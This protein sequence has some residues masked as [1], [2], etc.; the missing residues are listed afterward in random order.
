MMRVTKHYYYFAWLTLINNLFSI[1]T[2]GDFVDEGPQNSTDNI[3]VDLHSDL[4]TIYEDDDN[5]N[6]SSNDLETSLS[7]EQNSKK[8]K[9]MSFV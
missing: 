8:K 6:N 2:D 4:I 1:Y 5:T 7:Y 9:K 3:S